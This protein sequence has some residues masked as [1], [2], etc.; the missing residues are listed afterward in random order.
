MQYRRGEEGKLYFRMYFHLCT[1]LTF[2]GCYS[3]FDCCI[4]FWFAQINHI[5]VS[6]KIIVSLMWFEFIWIPWF[7]I[8]L[9]E[10][11]YKWPDKFP[12]IKPTSSIV[13]IA[14]LTIQ[15]A[16]PRK[17]EWERESN[18]PIWD[19]TRLQSNEWLNYRWHHTIADKYGCFERIETLALPHLVVSIYT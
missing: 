17:H 11:N 12:A 15:C 9:L 10:Y 19:V 14:G 4:A 3:I 13:S 2:S 1:L 8:W 7:Q 6:T 16:K 5:N 18:F